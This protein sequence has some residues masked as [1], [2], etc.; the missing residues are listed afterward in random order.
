MT[1]RRLGRRVVE[2]LEE[3]GVVEPHLQHAA[4]PELEGRV[5]HDEV[6]R[7]EDVAARPQQH[8]LDAA[9]KATPCNSLTDI[10]IITSI[11]TEE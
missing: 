11:S 9:T 1:S 8:H 10:L 7:L 6:D 3:D 4:H 5:A 2:D